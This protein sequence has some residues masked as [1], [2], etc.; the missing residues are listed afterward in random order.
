MFCTFEETSWVY[1][2]LF[3]LISPFTL[4]LLKCRLPIYLLWKRLR[5]PEDRLDNNLCRLLFYIKLFI[6]KKSNLNFW[7]RCINGHIRLKIC[8]QPVQ[9]LNA[10][11]KVLSCQTVLGRSAACKSQLIIYVTSSGK[12]TARCKYNTGSNWNFLVN[13]NVLS[14]VIHYLCTLNVF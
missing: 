13:K 10:Y 9:M 4:K 5:I 12:Y 2:N 7:R 8:R 1:T 11:A 3:T 14:L 6:P